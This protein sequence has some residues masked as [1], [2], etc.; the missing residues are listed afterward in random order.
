MEK[1]FQDIANR[2][3]VLT[4]ETLRKARDSLQK[5]NSLG[6]NLAGSMYNEMDAGREKLRRNLETKLSEE[7]LNS[8]TVTQGPPSA[9]PHP[10]P[11][12]PF[13][14]L[15]FLKNHKISQMSKKLLGKARRSNMVQPSPSEDFR[16]SQI[17]RLLATEKNDTIFNL[18]QQ[19]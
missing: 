11:D 6:S 16:E 13:D 10:K 15:S 2:P 19:N 3:E 1:V 4:G 14:I 5:A 12:S 7:V 9:P 17:S 18:Q 8:E